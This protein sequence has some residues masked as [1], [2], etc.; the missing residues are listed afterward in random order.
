MLNLFLS[1]QLTIN[2][3]TLLNCATVHVF[4]SVILT[5]TLLVQAHLTFPAP[6]H[7]SRKIPQFDKCQSYCIS[8][9]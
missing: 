3:C 4:G 2:K 9:D 7:G 6:G 1:K 8:C 5:H